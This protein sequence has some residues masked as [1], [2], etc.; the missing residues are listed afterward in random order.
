[1][2]LGQVEVIGPAGQVGCYEA[3]GEQ[4]LI[5]E[6]DNPRALF[7]DIRDPD[8]PPEENGIPRWIGQVPTTWALIAKWEYTTPPL[9]KEPGV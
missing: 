7:V 9:R 6:R 2:R 3:T 8:L 4:G 1:M 5:I